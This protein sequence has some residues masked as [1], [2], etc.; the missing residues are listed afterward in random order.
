MT[1][2]TKRQNKLAFLFK[3]FCFLVLDNNT[4][5]INLKVQIQK[6]FETLADLYDEKALESQLNESLTNFVHVML[7]DTRP[8]SKGEESGQN[9][10]NQ[11]VCERH[12]LNNRQTIRGWIGQ[13]DNIV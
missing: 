10:E 9:N 6:I 1:Y 7:S 5:I 12:F 13:E 8:I 4:Q 3:F 11:I 2:N